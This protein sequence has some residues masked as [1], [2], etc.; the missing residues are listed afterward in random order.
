MRTKKDRGPLPSTVV[1]VAAAQLGTKALVRAMGALQDTLEDQGFSEVE[2][3][4]A[5]GFPSWD[6]L[7]EDL[8]ELIR[9]AWAERAAE[10]ERAMRAEGVDPDTESLKVPEGVVPS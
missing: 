2:I 6:A 4:K 5:E 7:L 8:D 3:D 1:G 9:G 10:T